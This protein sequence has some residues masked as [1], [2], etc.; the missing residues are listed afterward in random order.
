[1]I[2]DF[3]SSTYYPPLSYTIVSLDITDDGGRIVMDYKEVYDVDGFRTSSL[4]ARMVWKMKV[5]DIN[6]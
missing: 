3:L 1:M 5:E 6:E 4:Y 2:E